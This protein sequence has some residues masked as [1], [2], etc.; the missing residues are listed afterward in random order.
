M[1]V[2]ACMYIFYDFVWCMCVY[3]YVFVYGCMYCICE[4]H[5]CMCECIGV[6]SVYVCI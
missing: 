1:A 4:R 5:V 3:M 2:C 6:Y